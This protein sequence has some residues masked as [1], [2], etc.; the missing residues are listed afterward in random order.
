[1]FMSR[2]D[3]GFCKKCAEGSGC[4]CSDDAEAPCAS[5][6]R[7]RARRYPLSQKYASGYIRRENRNKRLSV[8][9]RDQR[10]VELPSDGEVPFDFDDAL[11][12]ADAAEDSGPELSSSAATLEAIGELFGIEVRLAREVDAP[13]GARVSGRRDGNTPTSTASRKSENF[14]VANGPLLSFADVGG[15][16]EIKAELMQCVDM[17]RNHEKY[18]KFSV[19]TPKGVILEGPPGCGKTMIAKALAGE[20]G[21]G[22]IAVSGAEFQEKYVGVGAARVR[23][24]FGLAKKNTPCIVFIDEIDAI[25]RARS[26]EAD[27][28]NAERDSALNELLVQMDGF[29]TTPGIFMVAATNRADL[30][31]P[32][33]TRAGR[34]DKRIHVGKPDPDTRRAVLDIH[35]TGKPISR[36][37][38]VSLDTLVHD[39][40]GL[41]CADI[42]NTLNEAMLAAIRDNRESM[43][44]ADIEDALDRRLAGHQSTDIV[45]TSDMVDRVAVHEIGH[46]VVALLV[47][48][49]AKVRKVALNLRSPTSPGYTVFDADETPM[50]TREALFE[51]IMVLLAGRLAEEVIYGKSVTTGA[52]GDF[53]EARKLAEQM[54]VNYGMGASPLAYGRGDAAVGKMDDDVAAL[55]A[56]AN[57]AA[58]NIVENATGFI[59]E[60][61]LKLR[62]SGTLSLTDLEAILRDHHIDLCHMFHCTLH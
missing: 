32:A 51:H 2:R 60:A 44:A 45:M 54:V 61:A 59:Y 38:P 26:P 57:D 8:D 10:E 34:V 27:A 13:R 52:L 33:L 48:H 42:E 4:G 5:R 43:S 50:Y 49:H 37:S 58:R 12:A 21:T 19:R 30:L 6:G 3:G 39:T 22:F 31:D 28:S 17:L 46:A 25:G 53:S 20:S 9:E 55:L 14:E 35:L 23:E 29:K 41:S 16:G 1:M 47:H 18:A 56:E 11:D 24:L 36:K 62:E 15:Y 7:S 40:A